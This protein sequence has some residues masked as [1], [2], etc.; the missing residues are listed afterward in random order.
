MD[1]KLNLRKQA[2]PIL[3]VEFSVPPSVRSL[4]I[5]GPSG[6]GKTSLLRCLAGVESTVQGKISWSNQIGQEPVVGLVFQ[7][8]LLYPH[9]TVEGNLA[10]AEQFQRRS[11]KGGYLSNLTR[12][13]LLEVF[14]VEHL[15][16]SQVAHLSGGEQQRIA[17]VRA[18]LN[19]PD[20]LLLDEAVSAL[21]KR[22]KR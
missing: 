2:K 22:L 7:Q 1:I 12:T 5:Y 13:T 19:Q 17:I 4:G 21:D 3:N 10:F 14:E 8:G 11:D 9:L 16:Q 15:L 20:V 18:L 6:A